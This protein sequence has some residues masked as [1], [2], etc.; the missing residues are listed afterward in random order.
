M[1]PNALMPEELFKHMVSV[2]NCDTMESMGC[3]LRT[4]CSVLVPFHSLTSC[5]PHDGIFK[6]RSKRTKKVWMWR[7]VVSFYKGY[8]WKAIHGLHYQL[9]KGDLLFKWKAV[10]KEVQG[11]WT[12]HHVDIPAIRGTFSGAVAGS[13]Q[14]LPGSI[15]SLASHSLKMSYI[16]SNEL[17]E[18]ALFPNFPT[19]APTLIQ[20]LK[21][22]NSSP[23]TH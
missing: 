8:I 23:S 17:W 7:Y 10:V 4:R 15:I 2:C 12:C 1:G 13:L 21:L 11:K 22:C 19:A 18:R 9:T 14:C 20:M 6:A 5:W 3:H 16:H